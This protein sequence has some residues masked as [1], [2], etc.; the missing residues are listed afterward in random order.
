MSLYDDAYERKREIVDEMMWI[1][2]MYTIKAL[3]VVV[4]EIF[5]KNG[6]STEKYA[7]VPILTEAREKN[8]V[9]TEEEKQEQI[10]ILFSNLSVMQGNFERTHGDKQ[11]A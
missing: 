3:R 11:N 7:D 6:Q 10:Q 8:R 2:G 5:A 9:L 4:S 1:N